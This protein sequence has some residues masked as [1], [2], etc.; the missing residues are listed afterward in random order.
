MNAIALEKPALRP[1]FFFVVMASAVIA[2][3]FAGF[4]PTFYLRS[5][6]PQDRPM[7]VPNALHRMVA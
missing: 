6:F 1:R 5:S 2:T 4:A 7:S 3:A